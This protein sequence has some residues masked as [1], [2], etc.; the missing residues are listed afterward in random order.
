MRRGI[1]PEISKGWVPSLSMSFM[2]LS[3]LWF[4]GLNISHPAPD[5]SFNGLYHCCGGSRE[6]VADAPVRNSALQ[7]DSE[8]RRATES[9]P[10]E[11][12]LPGEPISAH[13]ALLPRHLGRAAEIPRLIE[14]YYVTRS[15]KMDVSHLLAHGL[16]LLP[17][18]LEHHKPA[19]HG[20]CDPNDG[21][22][23]DLRG[24]QSAASKPP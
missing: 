17:Q 6:A 8:R 22:C 13:G 15:A 5:G 24:V 23:L 19:D 20:F 3:P 9:P 12:V 21:H 10:C 7:I 4:T 18:T 11:A 14:L 1:L 16:V 2:K